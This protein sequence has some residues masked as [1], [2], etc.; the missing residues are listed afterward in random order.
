MARRWTVETGAVMEEAMEEVT[1]VTEVMA[2]RVEG[3][4]D[5]QLSRVQ[6]S[7]YYY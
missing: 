3:T 2:A 5:F 4:D 6:A 7:W 1:E